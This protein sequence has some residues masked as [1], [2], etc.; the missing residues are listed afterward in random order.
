MSNLCSD[1]ILYSSAFQF[2]MHKSNIHGYQRSFNEM[3]KSLQLDRSDLPQTTF[4]DKSLI[5][6]TDTWKLNIL[7][8]VPFC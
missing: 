1:I 6:F 7:A 8:D 5:T 4:E 3:I 2:E